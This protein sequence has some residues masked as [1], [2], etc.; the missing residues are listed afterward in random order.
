MVSSLV[1]DHCYN[2]GDFFGL[3]AAFMAFL[4]CTFHVPVRVNVVANTT[5]PVLLAEV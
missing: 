5:D 3:F 2:H 1:A 4:C